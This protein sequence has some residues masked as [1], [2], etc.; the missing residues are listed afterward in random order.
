[1]RYYLDKLKWLSITDGLT[2]LYNHRFFQEK[3]TKELKRAERYKR[4]LSLIIFDIDRFKVCNDTYGHR[5]GDAV[6]VKLA[7]IF[8]KS[9]RDID[10]TARYGGEEFTII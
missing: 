5:M 8:Q 4:F 9:V 7:K 6:L 2:H 10:I 1:M 3:L